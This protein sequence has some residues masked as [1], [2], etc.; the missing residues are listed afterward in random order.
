MLPP[1]LRIAIIGAGPAGLTLGVLLHKQ[2]IPFTIFELRQKPTEEELLRPAGSLDLHED[3]GLAAIKECGLFKEFSALT[4]DCT[5]A[6]RV[7]NMHGDLLYSDEG[8]LANRPEIARPKI[9]KLLL[10]RLPAS[11]I[12]WGYKLMSAKASAVPDA[13]QTELDFGEHGK[14]TFDLVIG[15]DGA[16]SKVRAFLTEEKPYYAGMHIITMDI[17]DVNSKYPL[18]A[19][20]IGT[21]SLQCLGKRHGIASQRSMQGSARIY[22]FLSVEDEHFVTTSGLKSKTPAQ[23]KDQLLC[24][25]SLFSLWGSNIKQLVAAACD[26]E[27]VYKPGQKI[28][29]KPLYTL[30]AGYTW[31]HHPGATLVGDAAHLMNPPAGEGVNLAMKDSML[32]AK[33][34]TK[35][36]S[37]D[38]Q[39]TASFRDTL[40][41]LL[42]EFESDMAVA[43]KKVAEMTKMVNNLQFG[44]DDA[45]TNMANFFKGFKESA[46]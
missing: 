3:S 11:S 18:L 24:D 36:H 8:D 17:R 6:S 44:S 35:A 34:I 25:D 32:L 4:G 5:E 43:A 27:T 22:I 14:E 23:A 33:A 42:V 38:H 13:T 20:W 10:S 31:E 19:D 37:A 30:P 29:I 40:D 41:S 39:N 2:G 12:K 1:Q 28:D 7:C 9:I 45:A 15:A 16:W 21:G 46:E 26:D